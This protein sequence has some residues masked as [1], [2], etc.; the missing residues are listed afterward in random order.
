V[1]GLC[2]CVYI[3]GMS[4]SLWYGVAKRQLDVF[5]QI[6]RLARSH[7]EPSLGHSVPSNTTQYRLNDRNLY[8][9]SN[10][11]LLSTTCDSIFSISPSNLTLT[12]PPSC[13]AL[14]LALTSPL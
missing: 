14:Q 13:F 2:E 4:C 12:C 7:H 6:M 3:L 5:R 8:L 9:S 11:Y 1:C 10:T